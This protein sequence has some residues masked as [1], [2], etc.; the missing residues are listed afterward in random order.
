[1]AQNPVDERQRLRRVLPDRAIALAM[2]NRWREAADVNRAILRI[3]PNDADAYNRLGKALLELGQ[4]RE[5]HEAYTRAVEL[6]PANVIAHKN[7]QRLVP[8]IQQGAAA[9]PSRALIP[10]AEP[11]RPQTFIEETGKTGVST[12]THLASGSVLLTLTAGDRVELRGQDGTLTAY[13]EAGAYLGQV[14]ARLAHR[15]LRF[16]AGGNRYAAAVT[17]VGERQL[18]LIIR[19]IYQAPAMQGR[20]SFPAKA[21]PPALRP[22]AREGASRFSGEEE[23]ESFGDEFEEETEFDAEEE[24]EEGELDEEEI[25]DRV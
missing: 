7:M 16:I 20:P 12:L 21:L 23:D 8:L 14:E 15:L 19:E 11:R 9:A 18:T 22:S 24:T 3:D 13:T 17:A 2:Q 25:D 4:Y 6:N 10:A 5:A 1:M